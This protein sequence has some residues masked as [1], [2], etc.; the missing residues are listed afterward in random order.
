MLNKIN[1]N[2]IS[3]QAIYS[4]FIEMPEGF[5]IN[6]L[7]LCHDIL[8]FSFIG[9]EF[10]FSKE[11]EKLNRYLQDFF[12]LKHK[13]NLVNTNARGD[14]YYPNQ[15]SKPILS[16]DPLD[17]R[18]SPDFVMLYGAQV[19]DC[20]V[21]VYY[22]DN[23]RKNRSW[24]IE[25]KTNMFVMFPSSNLYNIFNYQKKLLNFIQTTTYGSI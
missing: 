21:R 5:E 16:L 6:S 13:I 2:L 19:K 10:P 18:N 8:Q 11:W 7:K 25:L 17:L 20:V 3:E 15:V 23:R 24:D 14:I 9:K 22:D 12:L 1:K 4:G